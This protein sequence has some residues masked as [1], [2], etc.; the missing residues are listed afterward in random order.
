[1]DKY[2]ELRTADI[3]IPN[4]EARGLWLDFRIL[5]QVARSTENRASSLAPRALHA[6][7]EI[8]NAFRRFDGD[9]QD[10]SLLDDVLRK[11]RDI[12]WGVLGPLD[13]GGKAL[14]APHKQID[15]EKA[16]IWAIGHW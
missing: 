3:V 15:T 11:C 14:T 12:A 5:A 13:A 8:M 2:F 16:K 4:I 10:P 1:M 6:C 9:E 7:N